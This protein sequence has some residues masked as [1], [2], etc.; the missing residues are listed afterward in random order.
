MN[1]WVERLKQIR[2]EK[3]LAL[4]YV[5]ERLEMAEQLIAMIELGEVVPSDEQIEAIME[6]V[7]DEM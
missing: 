7:I 2:E 5:A 3:E 6:F 4:A 1:K